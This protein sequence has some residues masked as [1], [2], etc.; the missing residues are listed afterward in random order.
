MIVTNVPPVVGPEFG[1]TDVMV[2]VEIG[3]HLVIPAAHDGYKAKVVSDALTQLKV[4]ELTASKA[5]VPI[6]V[7]ASLSVSEERGEL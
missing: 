1:E 5:P 7:S 6:V 3:I 4:V 2:G